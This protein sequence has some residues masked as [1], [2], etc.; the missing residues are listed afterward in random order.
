[1]SRKTLPW[2]LRCAM[3]ALV[4]ACTLFL[5]GCPQQTTSIDVEYTQKTGGSVKI[6]HTIKW[7]PPGSYLASFDATQ[8]LLNLSLNNARITSTTGIANVSVIDLTN[9]QT[10]GQQ[11]FGYVVRGT[12]IY[13]QDPTAV[14]NWLQQFASYPS[15]DVIVGVDTD[16]QTNT[17]G[18]ASATATAQYQ[19]TG[20]AM[21]S[22][23][24]TYTTG[25]D[26]GQCQDRSCPP[27][28]Q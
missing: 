15:I 17:P 27:I 9:T 18:E 28:I 19:G 12:S 24:W 21:S 20:Y 3:V 11:S 10:V 14:Y 16:V 23:G 26:P 1:M 4:S 22:V 13:A 5:T 7:D 6:T 2:P 8:A 25:G